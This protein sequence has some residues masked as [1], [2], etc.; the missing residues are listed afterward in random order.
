[1]LVE[2]LFVI[3]LKFKWLIRGIK[4]FCGES[5]VAALADEWLRSLVLHAFVVSL[6]RVIGGR[7]GARSGAAAGLVVLVLR[8]G[9][10]AETK[11]IAERSNDDSGVWLAVSTHRDRDFSFD[12]SEV[13]LALLSLFLF[14][15]LLPLR[16]RL[17][18]RDFS[19]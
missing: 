7:G 1:M 5:V 18:E 6:R 12:F 15:A 9:T 11:Q 4:L 2:R 19:E 17:R 8:A 10:I 3:V 16:S 14:E 13:R